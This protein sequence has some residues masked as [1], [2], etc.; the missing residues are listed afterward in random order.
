MGLVCV[1]S[2]APE[3]GVP[4]WYLNTNGN[5]NFAGT[6]TFTNGVNA[7]TNAGFTV[8]N[9]GNVT[10]SNITVVNSPWLSSS[11][12]QTNYLT[13]SMLNC[14]NYEGTGLY[15]VRFAQQAGSQASSPTPVN[16]PDGWMFFNGPNN[17]WTY[18]PVPDWATNAIRS[19]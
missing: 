2:D 3:S 8:D 4:I 16:A 10:A 18:M 1:N 6:G 14:P 11:V 13:S 15:A 19:K 17:I 7:G 5:A 9:S 12:Y